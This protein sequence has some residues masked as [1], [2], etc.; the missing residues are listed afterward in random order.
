MIISPC[1]EF[2]EVNDHGDRETCLFNSVEECK[3]HIDEHEEP[4]DDGSWNGY[5]IYEVMPVMKIKASK[6][7]FEPVARPATT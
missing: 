1:G 6:I 2:L 4:S 7:D 5:V 3:S